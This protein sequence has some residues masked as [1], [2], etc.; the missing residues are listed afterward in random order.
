MQTDNTELHVH[1]DNYVYDSSKVIHVNTYENE[2]VKQT[3]IR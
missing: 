3:E 2:E 1:V